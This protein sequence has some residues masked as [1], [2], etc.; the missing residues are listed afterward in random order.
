MLRVLMGKARPD[1]EWTH[2]RSRSKM[3][4]ILFGDDGSHGNQS[5]GNQASTTQES[6]QVW[7]TCHSCARSEETSEESA[8]I[9]ELAW[10]EGVKV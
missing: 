3:T 1:H 4:T 2:S 7:E 10:I 8:D 9:S 5:N 6:I